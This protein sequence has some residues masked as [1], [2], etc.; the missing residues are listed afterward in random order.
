M[1]VI[2]TIRAALFIAGAF[3][4]GAVWGDATEANDM[5][6]AALP[7]ARVAMNWVDTMFNQCD[8][9]SAFEKYIHPSL[10]HNHPAAFDGDELKMESGV[11][12]N[13][14]RDHIKLTFRKVL[15][16][17][18]LVIMQIWVIRDSKPNGSILQEMMRIK[19]GRIVDHWDTHRDMQDGQKAF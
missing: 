2:R 4:S 1:R 7:E 15:V 17:R 18:D 5:A 9:K 19:D 11:V 6:D 12:A 10:Y 3:M 14:C 8:P 13:A 16:R